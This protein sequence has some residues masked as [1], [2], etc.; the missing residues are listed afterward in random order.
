MAVDVRGAGARVEAAGAVLAL[1]ARE[2]GLVRVMRGR[3]GAGPGRGR[4]RAVR[5]GPVAGAAAADVEHGRH[6]R[7]GGDAVHVLVEEEHGPL[8]GVVHVAVAAATRQELA[9]RGRRRQA[10]RRLGDG[11]LG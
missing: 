7:V 2:P 3:I 9:V 10:R 5:G 6:V 8:A 1:A 4:V 11:R